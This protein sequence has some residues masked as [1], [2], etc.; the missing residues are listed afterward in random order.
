MIKH[1]GRGFDLEE[2]GKDS[3]R[4]REAGAAQVLVEIDLILVEGFAHEAHPKIETG[5]DVVRLDLNRP[6]AVAAFVAELV[7]AA[8]SG[9]LASPYAPK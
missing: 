8:G 5:P 3:H 1:A 7:T 4:V 9:C 6:E 2:R